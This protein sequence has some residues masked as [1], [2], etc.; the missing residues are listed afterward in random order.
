[1]KQVE[2]CHVLDPLVNTATTHRIHRLA[3]KST[4]VEI[5]AAHARFFE[6]F[7]PALGLIVSLRK[8]VDAPTLTKL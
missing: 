8:P 1:M 6:S 3:Q 5:P 4:T 2:R 7:E